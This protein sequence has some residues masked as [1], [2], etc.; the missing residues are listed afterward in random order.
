[1]E[2]RQGHPAGLQRVCAVL[3]RSLAERNGS[4]L[5]V[6]TE[7]DSLRRQTRRPL[8]KHPPVAAAT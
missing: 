1:V 2:Q 7:L 5:I 4:A 3:T 6:G 8:A